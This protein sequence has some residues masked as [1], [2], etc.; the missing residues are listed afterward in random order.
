MTEVSLK[1]ALAEYDSPILQRVV[2]KKDAKYNVEQ[3]K[4]IL[5]KNTS[6][7]TLTEGRYKIWQVINGVKKWSVVADMKEDTYHNKEGFGF[8]SNVYIQYTPNQTPGTDSHWK[9]LFGGGDPSDVAATAASDIKKRAGDMLPDIP[10]G[11]V[12][13]IIILI[14]GAGAAFWFFRGRKKQQVVVTSQPTTA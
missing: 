5:H 1:Q 3:E 7:V 10:W 12:A 6:W 14:I 4:L 2:D 11:L 13:A 9:T 8:N